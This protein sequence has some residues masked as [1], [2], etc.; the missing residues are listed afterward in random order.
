[1]VTKVILI[2]LFILVLFIGCSSSCQRSLVD[3]KS[4][5]GNGLE[6]TINVYG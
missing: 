4:D 6:R 5:F 3:I 2:S 1:M